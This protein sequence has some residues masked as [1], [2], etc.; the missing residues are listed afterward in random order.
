MKSKSAK[1]KEQS[2]GGEKTR[3]CIVLLSKKVHT[4]FDKKKYFILNVHLKV[5]VC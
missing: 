1:S 5:C 3:V 2:K 4:T